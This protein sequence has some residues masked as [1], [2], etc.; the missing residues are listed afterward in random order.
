[1]HATWRFDTVKGRYTPAETEALVTALRELKGAEMRLIAFDQSGVA[2]RADGDFK[3]AL[4]ANEALAAKYPRK[5]VHRLRNASALLEA[6][7]GTRAQREA[8]TATRLEPN[9]ALAWKMLGWTLQHD[10]VGRRFGEGFDRA[11]AIAAYR[12]ARDARARRTPTSPRISPC[13]SSTTRTACV[14]HP[15]PISTW[16]SPSTRRGASC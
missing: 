9:S 10:A 4:Q 7:L 11:G 2:L 8:L 12:K 1:M 5:A 15:R 16:P 6:G 14:I 3:G 13:C